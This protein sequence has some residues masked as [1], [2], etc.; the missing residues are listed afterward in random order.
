MQKAL[1][2]NGYK[3]FFEELHLEVIAELFCMQSDTCGG[4]GEGVYNAP[5][6]PY[7]RKWTA[8]FFIFYWK[9]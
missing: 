8:L 3:A 1:P 9:F 2:K 7:P 6:H 4:L 5:N